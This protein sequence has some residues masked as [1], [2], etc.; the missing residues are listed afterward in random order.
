[1][2]IPGLVDPGP[3]SAQAGF[4]P[5]HSASGAKPSLGAGVPFPCIIIIERTLPANQVVRRVGLRGARAA[6]LD[7]RAPTGKWCLTPRLLSGS[8]WTLLGRLPPAG[9]RTHRPFFPPWGRSTT[10]LT[11][12]RRSQQLDNGDIG[13]DD[14]AFRHG[15]LRFHGP[16]SRPGTRRDVTA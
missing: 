15:L 8:W 6:A 2:K 16:A 3:V 14:V 12:A 11:R 13:E 1:M 9:A 10:S 4:L 5:F 7:G